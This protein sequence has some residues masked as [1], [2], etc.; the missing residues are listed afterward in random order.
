MA[1]VAPTSRSDGYTVPASEW[2][3]NTVDNPIALRAGAIAIASQAANDVFYA[4]SA[5]QMAR[6]AAGTAGQVLQTNGAGTPPSWVA[7]TQI[8]SVCNGRLTL[9]TAVPVT[10]TDVTAAGTLYFALYQ[11]NQ[12]G[13]YTGSA[14][15]ILS[16]AQLS[17]AV[18]AA[19]NQVYDAFVDYNAGTPALTLTAWTNDT[20]RATALTTQDGV[21][22]L[23]GTLGKRYVGTVRTITASQLNDAL[24]FRHVW[25]YYHR[26]PRP[27]RAVDT[28]NQWTPAGTGWLQ[29]NANTA[30]QIDLVCGVS[31]D[32]VDV[33]VVDLGTNTAGGAFLTV[34]IGEDGVTGPVA[35]CGNSQQNP[36]AGI[37]HTFVASLKKIPAIGR[38]Y[39][40]WIER[41][42]TSATTLFFGDNG[43]TDMQSGIHGT[44]LA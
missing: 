43:G 10:T 38:H 31:E 14:W 26:K 39:Y 37:R 28:A 24:G 5:T 20:T 7:L 11:G 32:A 8:H 41:T 19:A 12:I 16:I 21:L 36:A 22:V 23:T 3:Q 44:W 6:L 30:N 2:N 1:Y 33:Q 27:L 40:T 13:L 25:N 9:T 35:G 34:G 4:S 18:P 17:V 42:D 29:A 15:A